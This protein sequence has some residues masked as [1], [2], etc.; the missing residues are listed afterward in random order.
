MN[1]G[2]VFLVDHDLSEMAVVR[3]RIFD[4]GLQNLN[5]KPTRCAWCIASAKY[6][7]YEMTPFTLFIRACRF[8]E[9][10]YGLWYEVIY[11]SCHYKPGN[12]D[13]IICLWYFCSDGCKPIQAVRNKNYVSKWYGFWISAGTFTG[14]TK[15]FTVYRQRVCLVLY[16]KLKILYFC[17]VDRRG[18]DLDMSFYKDWVVWQRRLEAGLGTWKNQRGTQVHQVGGKSYLWRPVFKLEFKTRCKDDCPRSLSLAKSHKRTAEKYLVLGVQ[19][20]VCRTFPLLF[21]YIF[22]LRRQNMMTK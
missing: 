8:L 16:Y 1:C 4:N 22:V 12:G 17:I 6:I 13:W 2:T 14:I 11:K 18:Y 15:L 5:S 10:I 21:L 7:F 3:T 20:H 19:K 9:E